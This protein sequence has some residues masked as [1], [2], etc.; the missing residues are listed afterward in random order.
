MSQSPHSLPSAEAT[1]LIST[2]F[3]Q[4]TKTVCARKMLSLW[5]D[6]SFE[7]FNKFTNH[8][9]VDITCLIIFQLSINSYCFPFKNT[10]IHT[11]FIFLKIQA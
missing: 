1:Y 11:D 5:Y 4:Q 10:T 8:P 6:L 3:V 9:F 7:S 2:S